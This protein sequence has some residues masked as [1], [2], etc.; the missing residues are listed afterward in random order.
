MKCQKF[1]FLHLLQP[2]LRLF[3]SIKNIYETVSLKAVA[4][5]TYLYTTII[6]HR[7]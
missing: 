3:E 6:Y 4:K 7:T 5:E 1:T 2:I